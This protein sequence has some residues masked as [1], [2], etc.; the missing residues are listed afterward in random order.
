MRN[1]YRE[2]EGTLIDA[3]QARSYIAE[4]HG[5]DKEEAREG[6]EAAVSEMLA[7]KMLTAFEIMLGDMD[8]RDVERLGQYLLKLVKKFER[9]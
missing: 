7:P 3:A 2:L 8:A 9:F 5:P 1:E 4:N 6:Y